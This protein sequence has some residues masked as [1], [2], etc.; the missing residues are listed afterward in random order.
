[1]LTSGDLKSRDSLLFTTPRPPSGPPECQKPHHLLSLP[2]NELTFFSFYHDSNQRSKLIASEPRSSYPVD[3]R[4][5]LHLEIGT[6]GRGQRKEIQL[7]LSIEK[8]H[9]EDGGIKQFREKLSQKV[10]PKGIVGGFEF[11]VLKVNLEQ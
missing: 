1:M 11:T 2:A 10:H 5:T 6:G 3:L 9:L 8:N 7:N 4:S